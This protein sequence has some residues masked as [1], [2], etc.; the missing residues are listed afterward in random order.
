MKRKIAIGVLT[1]ISV[2]AS[3]LLVNQPLAGAVSAIEYDYDFKT[4]DN[5]MWQEKWAIDNFKSHIKFTPIE[6]DNEASC[7]EYERT[8][9]GTFETLGT[10][11]PG[12]DGTTTAAAG[13]T[14]TITGSLKGQICG[15][16]KDGITNASPEDLTVG[17][18]NG[19]A[20][21]YFHHF[22]D[23]ISGFTI[24]DWG[25][26]FASCGNGTW[27]DN[28]ATETAWATDKTAMGD[29]KGEPAACQNPT[30]APTANPQAGKQSSAGIDGKVCAGQN[31]NAYT[32]LRLD[33]QPVKDVN[34]KFVYNGEAKYAKTQ[35]DGRAGVAYGYASDSDVQYLPQ[36]GYPTQLQKAVRASDCNVVVTAGTTTTGG[37]VL[38]ASTLAKTGTAAT[39]LINLVGLAGV[40][41]TAAGSLILKRK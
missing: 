10:K 20:D 35:V 22:F 29:I 25:W 7:Y 15:D 21:K 3:A 28:E 16:F 26:V 18:Y 14:G 41:L 32:V 34:V 11:S 27:T 9:G 40:S 30:P 36:D 33:G 13:I 1:S 37:Q 23:N 6:T 12:G 24:T 2:F 31:F 39:T 19:Y 38:G 17:T 5:S 4:Y 8:D